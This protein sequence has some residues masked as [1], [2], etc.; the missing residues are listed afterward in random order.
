VTVRPPAADLRHSVSVSVSGSSTS[1]QFN[2]VG[3]TVLYGAT[4]GQLFVRGKA[5][6]RFAVRILLHCCVL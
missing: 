2:V 5:G 1:G 4:G 3:N 6:E